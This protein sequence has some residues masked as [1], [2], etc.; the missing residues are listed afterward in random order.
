MDMVIPPLKKAKKVD[1]TTML[2]RI[3]TLEEA[4]RKVWK[5]I[6]RREIPKVSRSALL[7]FNTFSITQ[8]IFLLGVQVLCD[9]LST[10]PST[11]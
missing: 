4:Q 8:T 9:G 1:D 5:N 11:I 10:T 2:K 3:K 7:G 6:A